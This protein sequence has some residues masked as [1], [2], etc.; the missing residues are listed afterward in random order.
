MK[1][2]VECRQ[3][4]PIEAFMSIRHPGRP[5]LRCQDCRDRLAAWEREVRPAS[6]TPLPP[7]GS[8]LYDAVCLMC[9][10][11]QGCQLTKWQAVLID[12]SGL[13]TRCQQCGGPRYLEAVTDHAPGGVGRYANQY[14]AYD[15]A[16]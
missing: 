13:L 14:T 10:G 9:G 3:Q 1:D 5:T 4:L 6:A 12:R 11:R 15:E 8:L 2:C 7:H 16:A